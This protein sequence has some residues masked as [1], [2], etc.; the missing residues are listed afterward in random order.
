MQ[1]LSNIQPKTNFTAVTAMRLRV[2][3][4]CPNVIAVVLICIA[5]VF[6]R[7]KQRTLPSYFG[8]EE[9]CTSQKAAELSKRILRV[10][11]YLL[12]LSII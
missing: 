10:S 2:D 1:E 3:L 11:N 4:K 12:A 9:Q 8:K 7:T 6:Y 5:I